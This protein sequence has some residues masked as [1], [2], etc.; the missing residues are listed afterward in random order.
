M[1]IKQYAEE[2]LYLNLL[3]PDHNPSLNVV[4]EETLE[5]TETEIREEYCLLPFSVLQAWTVF[6]HRHAKEWSYLQCKV[7]LY[8]N[9]SKDNSKQM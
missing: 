5:E 2:T 4:R 8:V 7:P 3:F 1:L 9:I 6:S